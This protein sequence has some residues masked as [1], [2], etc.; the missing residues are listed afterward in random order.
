MIVFI[1][2]LIMAKNQMIGVKN[3]ETK[4]KNIYKSIFCKREN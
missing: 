1:L 4:D 2:A 3:E